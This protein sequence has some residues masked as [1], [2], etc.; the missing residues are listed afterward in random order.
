M[1]NRLLSRGLAVGLLL[2]S[3]V[4][5]AGEADFDAA[6]EPCINGG[7]SAQGIY[8]TQALEDTAALTAADT[9]YALEPCISGAVSAD[10]TMST[11]VAADPTAIGDDSDGALSVFDDFG[12]QYRLIP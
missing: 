3:T 10:G 7:V 4:V 9:D 8:P 6:L 11:E 1:Y 12:E 2:S 5:A